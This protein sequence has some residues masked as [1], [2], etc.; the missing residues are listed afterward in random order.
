MMVASVVL[1]R[2]GGFAARFGG[3]EGDGQLFLGF[4]LADELAQPARPEFQ[5]KAIFFAG[6]RGAHEAF[7]IVFR[8]A[9][10]ATGKSTGVL[11]DRAT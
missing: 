8:I 7:G 6:A 10:H 5:F 3:F 4:G 1:P 9:C 11:A 2:P